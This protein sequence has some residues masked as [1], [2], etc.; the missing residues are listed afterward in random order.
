MAKTEV[1]VNEYDNHE[2][3]QSRMQKTK[4]V[5]QPRPIEVS[6][7]MREFD[8]LKRL[9][10]KESRIKTWYTLAE[11]SQ[12]AIMLAVGKIYVE[13]LW[14]TK[15]IE[16]DGKTIMVAS[17]YRSESE[18]I[19]HLADLTGTT[20]KNL[21]NYIGAYR[22]YVK[23]KRF[24]DSMGYS[25]DTAKIGHMGLMDQAVEMLE[26]GEVT[27]GELKRILLDGKVQDL[28]DLLAG[29]LKPAEQEFMVRAEEKISARKNEIFIGD[30][31]I[32]NIDPTVADTTIK[33]GIMSYLQ[34]EKKKA[35]LSEE[36]R[37]LATRY[38]NKVL[39][40]IKQDKIPVVIPVDS[41]VS[42]LDSFV[43]AAEKHMASFYKE[44]RAKS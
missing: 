43:R 40:T 7:V 32:I 38:Q 29:E 26:R 24:L 11:V 28:V 15:E 44:W 25:V 12:F 10:D 42:N 33:E 6:A 8:N 18:Y 27:K 21:Y 5:D 35:N 2:L 14:M 9:E 30:Q 19:K 3:V 39:E 31:K 22:S 17:G 34:A 20:K 23:H 4:A 36:F 16:Q 41:D 13:A 1:I 37:D